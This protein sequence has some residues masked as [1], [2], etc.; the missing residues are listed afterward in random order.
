M[1][2]LEPCPFCGGKELYGIQRL[3]NANGRLAVYC[4][5]CKT[6]FSFVGDKTTADNEE[7]LSA[8][9]KKKWNTR[10]TLPDK[11]L[12]IKELI[13][14][15]D[16]PVWVVFCFN[17][18]SG[19]WKVCHGLCDSEKHKREIIRFDI[20]DYEYIDEYGKKWVAYRNP[21]KD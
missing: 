14:M 10:L 16:E 2:N 21:P 20:G 18:N 3:D 12:T 7:S 13:E 6:I 17:K 4:G 5:K 15:K 19:H 11:P 1:T 8:N 9:I